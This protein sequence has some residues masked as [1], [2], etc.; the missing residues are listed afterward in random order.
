MSKNKYRHI[1]VPNGGYYVYYPSYN[2]II[3]RNTCGFENW[4]TFLD[5]PQFQLGNAQSHEVFRQIKHK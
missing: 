3:L 2:N 5:I 4:G 1:F